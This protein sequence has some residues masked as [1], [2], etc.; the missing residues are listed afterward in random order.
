MNCTIVKGRFHDEL[1]CT[2]FNI[3]GIHLGIKS[4]LVIISIILI[5]ITIRI[6]KIIIY[7]YEHIM[8]YIRTRSSLRRFSEASVQSI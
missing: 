5:F 8:L 4:L 1:I 2:P 3:L 7:T 6:D